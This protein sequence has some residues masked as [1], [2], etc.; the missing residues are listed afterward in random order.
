MDEITN[1]GIQ[2][3]L[4]KDEDGTVKYYDSVFKNEELSVGGTSVYISNLKIPHWWAHILNRILLPYGESDSLSVN[5][6]LS[7][8]Y[9]SMDLFWEDLDEELG[10]SILDWCENNLSDE[11]FDTWQSTW[12]ESD[13]ILGYLNPLTRKFYRIFVYKEDGEKKWN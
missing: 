5:T 6:P 9:A 1:H 4:L 7:S 13:F 10:F 8:D 2:G 11:D 12:S 3:I